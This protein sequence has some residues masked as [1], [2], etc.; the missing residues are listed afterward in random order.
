MIPIRGRRLGCIFADCMV[1]H[2]QVREDPEESFT[3]WGSFIAFS[4]KGAA[5]NNSPLNRLYVSASY[6]IRH[7]PC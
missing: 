7:G 6:K 2:G 3:L 1:D 5:I 4:L